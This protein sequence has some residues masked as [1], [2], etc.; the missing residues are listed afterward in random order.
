MTCSSLDYP[1]K[2]IGLIFDLLS[3]A[4]LQALCRVSRRLRPIAEPCLYSA[5]R[6]T[7][8]FT[9]PDAPPCPY[10]VSTRVP[11]LVPLLRA[12]SCRPEL[13]ACVK[14]IDLGCS[15]FNNL[16]AYTRYKDTPALPVFAEGADLCELVAVVERF[17][18]PYAGRWVQ[19]LRGG[20]K[21]AFVALLLAL[22]PNLQHL[23]IDEEYVQGK[24]IDM[25]LAKVCLGPTVLGKSH[26][27]S[28]AR[29]LRNCD[30]LDLLSLLYLPA[31]ESLSLPNDPVESSSWQ[32]HARLGPMTSCL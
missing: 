22:T 16:A 7:W 2:I 15:G 11:P 26:S 12:I 3:S 4:E 10:P 14:T 9:W 5:L 28:D 19:E 27:D 17:D 30:K 32:L 1:L 31:A 24:D 20:R 21:A 18:V 6:W 25:I 29:L 23:R 8:R 13:A